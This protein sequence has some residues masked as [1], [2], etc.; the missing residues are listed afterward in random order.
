[1]PGRQEYGQV[2]DKSGVWL[3]R[4]MPRAQ[5]CACLWVLEYL[6]LLAGIAH[7]PAVRTTKLTM[8]AIDPEHETLW[9]FSEPKKRNLQPRVCICFQDDVDSRSELPA[10]QRGLPL[11]KQFFHFWNHAHFF[12][13]L[14]EYSTYLTWLGEPSPIP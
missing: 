9:P 8:A 11:D 14:E 6:F 4:I 13:R 7:L 10:L 12:A 5:L 1:M 2:T 3:L